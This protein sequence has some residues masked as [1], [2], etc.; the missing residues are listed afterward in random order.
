[1][2]SLARGLGKLFLEAKPDDLDV[3]TASLELTAS[4]PK[5]TNKQTTVIPLYTAPRY[6]ANLAYRHILTKN[7]FF[8]LYKTSNSL[9]IPPSAYRH[10]FSMY[11]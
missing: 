1:M 11:R 5:Q 8:S 2:P 6:T 10:N 3:E 4:D 9:V 7:G